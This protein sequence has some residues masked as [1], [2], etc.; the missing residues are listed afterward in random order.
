MSPEKVEE[1]RSNEGS[2]RALTWVL[3][4]MPRGGL[5]A[6]LVDQSSLEQNLIA[7]GIEPELAARMAAMA[8]AE[9]GVAVEDATD[10]LGANPE[11]A[12]EQAVTIASAMAESRRTLGDLI[13][14]S[15]E[16]SPLGQ[17]YRNL[18]PLAIHRTGLEGL[19]LV[20]RFPILTGNFGYTRG[21]PTPG[22]STLRFFQHSRSGNVM[23]YADLQETEA[24]FIRLDPRRV[25][26]WLEL[27][28]FDLDSWTTPQDARRA[29][30]ERSS[31]MRQRAE[32]LS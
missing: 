12:V 30:L 22:K 11:R 29:I 15:D 6:V 24:Y 16:N 19:D 9:G 8:A 32:T 4:G 1:L 31:C 17:R 27:R 3:E 14:G 20:D 7:K 21:D 13:D 10:R 23:V 26:K 28:G 2:K 5:G 25:A 18:Y